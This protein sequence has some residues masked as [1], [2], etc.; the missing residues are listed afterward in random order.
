MGSWAEGAETGGFSVKAVLPENQLNPD[1][2]YYDLRVKPGIEQTLDL[3]LYN[4]TKEN[5]KVSV[6]INPGITND[7]GLIDYSEREKNYQYDESLKL[8]ITDIASTDKEVTIPAL[9]KVTT[10]IRLKIPN[11][12]FKGMVL[13]GIYLTSL[14][15]DKDNQGN[16]EGG[17]QIK[18][19]VVYSVGIKL[20]EN[21]ELVE[22]DL[23]Y[24]KGQTFAAQEAGRNIIKS[25]IRNLAPINVDELSYHAKIY[26]KDDQEVLVERAV[27]GYRMAPN[28]YFHYQVPWGSQPFK[29][30]KYRVEL[31][32]E[33]KI[34]G[35]SWQWQDEFEITQA[36]A[37][38]LNES[39]IDI[40][41]TN[42]WWLYLALGIGIL[43]LVI[44]VIVFIVIQK[45]RKEQRRRLE[46]QRK[47]KKRKKR[48]QRHSEE[49]KRPEKTLRKTGRKNG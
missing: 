11:Q 38:K 7:N 41:E 17:M 15:E 29:A 10:N 2:T 31:S 32:A 4:S 37:K 9:S 27:S 1:V 18:N 26:A 24:E 13:G 30:G 47:K 33:S 43:L 39:A 20:T 6:M 5:Q 19:K 34:T 36:E 48:P 40:E 21:D 22:A 28:S 25:K 8:A 35:Q 23:L 3:E 42:N 44:L 45:R 49:M 14:S 46:M 12:S 16:S